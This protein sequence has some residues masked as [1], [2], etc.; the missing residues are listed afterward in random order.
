MISPSRRRSGWFH[1]FKHHGRRRSSPRGHHPMRKTL[2]V[3]ARVCFLD[4]ERPQAAAAHLIIETSPR[5]LPPNVAGYPRTSSPLRCRN[6]VPRRKFQPRRDRCLWSD[7]T[8]ETAADLRPPERR[9]TDETANAALWST[10]DVRPLW[11]NRRKCLTSS[12]SRGRLPCAISACLAARTAR[13][14]RRPAGE[15]SKFASRTDGSNHVLCHR[16]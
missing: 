6:F 10:N 4:L 12:W 9:E 15:L 16:R 13:E 14:W 5:V 3:A 7:L 1:K 11:R 2:P 8:L